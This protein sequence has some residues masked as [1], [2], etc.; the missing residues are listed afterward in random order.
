[1]AV[2]LT[3]G[4]GYIGSHTAVSLLQAGYGVVTADN[5][6][7]SS[8]EAL[9]RVGKIAGRAVSAFEADVSDPAVLGRVF[10]QNEIEAVIH[11][12]GFK[13]VGESVRVPLK[14]YRNN[15]D[16]TL[17]LLET[18]EK[19]GVKN[20][21]FSSSATVYGV[22]EKLPLSEDLQLGSCQNPYGQTK[23]MIERIIGD[24]AAANPDFSAVILRYF[25]PVGAHPSGL[26]GE[27]P[28]GEPNNLMPYIAKVA[29]GILPRLHIFGNDYETRDGTGVRDYIHVVDLAEGHLAAMKKCMNKGGVHIFN[30]GTG[31]GYSV[32]DVVNSFIRAA[33]AEVPYVFD[34]RRP[35]DIAEYYADPAKAG[36]DLGWHA[37][38]SLDD[39]CRDAWNFQIKTGF[40]T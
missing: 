22:P 8:P 36:R 1:M 40:K 14:Y 19:Y 7:N 13:A 23:Q 18:M 39:M 35:G 21:V 38:L 37:A 12:A 34:A 16:C 17:T 3:G 10:E 4:A 25:N 30:L 31:E 26:I 24:Y 9:R 6:S 29:A 33:G 11:F 2:L 28:K 20:L 32:L 27:D 5:Y 15:I